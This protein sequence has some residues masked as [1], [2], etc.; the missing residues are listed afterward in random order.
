MKKLMGMFLLVVILMVGLGIVPVS[1]VGANA[2]PV[3]KGLWHLDEGSGVTAYDSTANNN[4]GTIYGA[5]WVTP[6]RFGRALSF[7]GVDDYVDCGNDASLKITSALTVEAWINWDTFGGDSGG[8]AMVSKG[9]YDEGFMLY[10]NTS[11]PYNRVR[12]R[13]V[14]SNGVEYVLSTT[15]LVAGTWYHVAMVYDGSYLKLYINGVLE[16]SESATGSIRWPHAIPQHCYLGTTY[17][18]AGPKFDGKIDEVRIWDGALTA[19]QIEDSY[20]LGSTGPDATVVEL[21]EEWLE[22][23]EFVIFTSSFY[24]LDAVCNSRDTIIARILSV[25][26]LTINVVQTRGRIYTPKGTSGCRSFGPRAGTY[27]TVYVGKGAS[28]PCKSIHLLLRLTGDPGR[29]GFNAQFN[30]YD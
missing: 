3:I 29:L 20:Q 17:N 2:V 9:W 12:G 26:G 7:D 21:G 18:A 24:G 27:A 22:G 14:T 28:N 23:G 1:P 16:H 6:G 13:V 4:D 19:A 5:S 10:Q 15:P 11:S 25:D 30:P 8:Y